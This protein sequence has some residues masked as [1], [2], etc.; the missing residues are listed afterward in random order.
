MSIEPNEP[1]PRRTAEDVHLNSVCDCGEG[2]RHRVRS[3]PT[4][5]RAAIREHAR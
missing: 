5:V 1:R 3:C 2:A 4:R